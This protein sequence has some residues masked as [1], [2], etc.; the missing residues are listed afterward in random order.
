MGGQAK[1]ARTYPATQSQ[2]GEIYAR[3]FQKLMDMGRVCECPTPNKRDKNG[4]EIPDTSEGA[5]MYGECGHTCGHAHHM[6]WLKG[7]PQDGHTA[8]RRRY[9]DVYSGVFG[10]TNHPGTRGCGDW[11]ACGD[12]PQVD[13]APPRGTSPLRGNSFAVCPIT[14]TAVGCFDTMWL[15]MGERRP[16]LPAGGGQR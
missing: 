10:V 2:R 13:S 5:T 4:D 8:I 12:T 7:P 14:H 6:A 11:S 15:R 1:A 9:R 3:H 16:P